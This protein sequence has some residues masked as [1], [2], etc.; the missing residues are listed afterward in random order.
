MYQFNAPWFFLL[1]P[2]PLLMRI[3]FVSHKENSSRS[4][5]QFFFPFTHRLKKV[6]CIH[7]NKVKNSRW[8][9]FFLSMSWILSIIALMQPEKVDHIKKVKNKG[10]DLLLAVDISASMQALDFSTPSKQINRLDVTK[11]VVGK[12]VRGRKGDRVGLIT[13]GQHAYLHVPLTFDTLSVVKMLENTVSGMAGNATAIGDAIGLSVRTLRERPKGSRVLILLTD[14]ID[15]SSSIPPLEATKL[16]QEYGIRIYTIGVGK[17]GAVPF[18]TNGTYAMAEIPID[19]ELLQNIAETTGGQYF[20]ATN[21]KALESIYHTIDQLE[22][23]ESEEQSLY[24]REPFYEYPLLGAI[25]FFL[26]FMLYQGTEFIGRK[27]SG[28]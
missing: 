13:F 16:A 2:L 8:F 3:F 7:K 22:K 9:Y 18:P 11:E 25:F 20:S 23:S 1:L 6:F 24:I 19:E 10:Y 26:L 5:P 27:I 12:F 4:V 14:G 17:K 21:H 28:F 15:N